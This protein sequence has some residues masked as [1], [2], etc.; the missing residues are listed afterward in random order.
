MLHMKTEDHDDQF[1]STEEAAGAFAGVGDMGVEAPNFMQVDC[2]TTFKA[3]YAII[4][5]DIVFH[6]FANDD[7]NRLPNPWGYWKSIFPKALER[8]ASDHFGAE[9]PRL[10]AAY[11]DELASWW[12]K[13]A[14]F[15][16]VLDPHVFAQRFLE[17]LDQ[18]LDKEMR[19]S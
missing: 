8:V 15:D 12:L 13:A 16:H 17:K 2:Y 1:I 11:A 18:E 4:G 6:F 14:S 3:E 9:Y 5:S 19:P 10:Q 7:I